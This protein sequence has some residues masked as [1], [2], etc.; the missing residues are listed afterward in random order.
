MSLETKLD[1]VS[2]RCLFFCHSTSQTASSTHHLCISRGYPVDDS[3]HSRVD[4]VVKQR[5]LILYH[6]LD[7]FYMSADPF[8]VVVKQRSG[9]RRR[10]FR[11]K[12]DLVLEPLASCLSFL[13][14]LLK[15]IPSINN[16]FIAQAFSC[17]LTTLHQH[18]ERCNTHHISHHPTLEA[19]E[20]E[21]G[22]AYHRPISSNSLQAVNVPPD[23][24]ILVWIGRES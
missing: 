6:L 10:G 12:E 21:K 5:S 3:L 20:E 4:F 8:D 2:R 22:Y 19:S 18:H 7:R 23:F 16:E 24:E 17:S 1:R 15:A 11:C 13:V 9:T 14:A